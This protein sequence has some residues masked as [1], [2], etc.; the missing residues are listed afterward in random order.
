MLEKVLQLLSIKCRHSRTSQ[1][2]TASRAVASGGGSWES[3]I[4]APTHYVVC[5]DCGQKFSYDWN[6]MRIVR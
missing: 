2:F 1:P 3:V 5:L 4:A 6:E